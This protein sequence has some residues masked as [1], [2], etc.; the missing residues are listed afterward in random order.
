MVSYNSDHGTT[1]DE[2]SCI[3]NDGDTCYDFGSVSSCNSFVNDL[4]AQ[5]QTSYIIAFFCLVASLVV[6]GVSS[7]ALKNVPEPNPLQQPINEQPVTAHAV[8][9]QPPPTT[10]PVLVY[11]Q[12]PINSNATTAK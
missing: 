9:V 4:P 1:S 12:S 5:I 6:L 3:T 8:V 7:N 2:C 10:A 11:V